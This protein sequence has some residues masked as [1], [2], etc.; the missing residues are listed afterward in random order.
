MSNK[1]RTVL[2]RPSDASFQAYKDF[3]MSITAALTGNSPNADTSLTE[4]EWWEGYENFWKDKA[5]D[6]RPGK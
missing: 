5:T 6:K 2:G 1:N 4:D 3:V